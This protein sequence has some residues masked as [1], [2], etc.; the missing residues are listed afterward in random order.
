ML[1]YP[2]YHLA[3]FQC[4]K[5]AFCSLFFLAAFGESLKTPN[6]L[7]PLSL[8]NTHAYNH[9]SRTAAGRWGSIALYRRYADS[10]PKGS[11]YCCVKDLIFLLQ[12]LTH[13]YCNS[14]NPSWMS[15]HRQVIL[16]VFLIYTCD[17]LPMIGYTPWVKYHLVPLTYEHL[18]YVLSN[19]SCKF[20]EVI[21]FLWPLC[22]KR[23][24]DMGIYSMSSTVLTNSKNSLWLST[25][26]LSHISF[27]SEF[28]HSMV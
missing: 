11:V 1:P 24:L 16:T 3:N 18:D 8:V 7:V 13:C 26:A 27:L 6:T 5:K 9:F 22:C 14:H 20:W 23:A 19:R 17:G 10:F 21:E 4:L 12:T 15:Y 25:V 28:C 2:F